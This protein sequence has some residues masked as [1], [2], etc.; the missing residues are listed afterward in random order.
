MRLVGVSSHHFRPT[1]LHFAKHLAVYCYS[2]ENGHQ[3]QLALLIS[4]EY[5]YYYISP[6]VYKEPTYNKR[7]NLQKEDVSISTRRGCNSHWYI[8]HKISEYSSIF[9]LSSNT[10]WMSGC[11]WISSL[12]LTC[13]ITNSRSSSNAWEVSVVCHPQRKCTSK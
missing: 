11:M 4:I 9:I 1:P 12:S 6:L 10:N 7:H 3:S 13:K 8:S 2:G 5:Y